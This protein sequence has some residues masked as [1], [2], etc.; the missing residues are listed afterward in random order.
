[1]IPERLRFL[2]LYPEWCWSIFKGTPLKDGENRK[3]PF[4]SWAVGVP[5]ALHSGAYPGGAGSKAERTAALQAWTSTLRRVGQPLPEGFTAG[6]IHTRC[7]LG[8]VVPGESVLRSRSPW[9]ARPLF[10]TPFREI[11][12]FREP[13]PMERGGEGLKYLDPEVHRACVAAFQTSRRIR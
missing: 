12:A 4:P 9:H 1:M 3:W 10:F 13:V 11:Y 8:V 7:I 2:T 6:Q 5:L